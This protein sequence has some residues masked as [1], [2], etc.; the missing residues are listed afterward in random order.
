[1]R[2]G[3]LPLLVIALARTTTAAQPSTS[4]PAPE[5][6]N[7]ATPEVTNSAAP[8]VADDPRAHAV[9]LTMQ[10]VMAA[11]AGDCGTVRTIEVQVR[12]LDPA[13][14][15]RA[16]AVDPAIAPCLTPPTVGNDR[17]GPVVGVGFGLGTGLTGDLRLGWML[18]PRIAVFATA[19]GSQSALDAGSDFRLLGIGARL[20]IAG[21]IFL[22]GRVGS[23]RGTHY[24]ID[25][26]AMRHTTSVGYLAGLGVELVRSRIFG[27]E[28]NAD[29]MKGGESLALALGLGV[30]FY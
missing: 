10:A 3:L 28:L 13:Y 23:A 21:R 30:T 6:A 16:F 7:G 15:S 24:D 20:W 1:M 2:Q 11:R 14:R 27:L 26:T 25:D 4:T 29:F 17:E 5:I 9:Q 12:D 19:V 22:D 18:H 8:K